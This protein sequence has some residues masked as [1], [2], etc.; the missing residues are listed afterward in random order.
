MIKTCHGPR[1]RVVA[2]IAGRCRLD[3]TCAF[4]RCSLAVMALFAAALHL[5]VIDARHLL[6]VLRA[7]A[8]FAVF[9]GGYMLGRFATT[10]NR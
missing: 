7:V 9:S 10:R 4:A 2:A 3:M 8:T 1:Y 6:P 5:T